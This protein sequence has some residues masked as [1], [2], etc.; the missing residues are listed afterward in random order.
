MD[1]VKKEDEIKEEVEENE[2]DEE[3]K[4]E[5][6]KLFDA[7]VAKI[8]KRFEEA[9]EEE[10]EKMAKKAGVYNPEVQEK[11]QRK[12]L[13]KRFKSLM[14]ALGRGDYSSAKEFV[15]KDH[16]TTD[17][18]EIVDTEINFEI[19]HLQEEYGVARQLFRT[20]QLTKHKYQAK[21]LATDVT[22]YWVDEGASITASSI[23]LTDNDLE[24]DKLAA[25]ASFTNELLEDS[26]VDL[27]SFLTRRVAEVFAKAEDEK[28]LAD[29]SDGIIYQADDSIVR[30]SETDIDS[31]SLGDDEFADKL[32]DLQGAVS[33]SVRER[34]VY[35]MSWELFAKVRKLRDDNDQPLFK[36]LSEEGPMTI[37]GKPVVISDVMP[38]LSDADSADD[39]VLMFGDFE[40]GCYLGYKGGIR[41]DRATQGAIDPEGSEVNLFQTDRQAVRFIQRTGYAQVLSNTVAVL[42]TAVS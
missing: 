40:R 39:P 6:E 33:K 4:E 23:S 25:I 35:V 21:E 31:A 5:V 11:E 12:Q 17:P 8:E 37:H 1:E 18:S 30:V 41:I 26:E 9:L 42:K 29:D 32:L 16:D 20:L 13:N 24:L 10:K 7:K 36:H 22:A 19:L 28:F 38:E 15:K 3:I 14:K 34:G 2:V 27:I